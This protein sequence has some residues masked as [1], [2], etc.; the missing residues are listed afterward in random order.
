MIYVF[1]TSVKKKKNIR[2]LIPFLNAICFDGKWNFDLEDCDKILRVE[3]DFDIKA[4]IVELLLSKGFEC[5]EL[6]TL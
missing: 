3:S 6:Q 1:K 2:V 5:V 4:E